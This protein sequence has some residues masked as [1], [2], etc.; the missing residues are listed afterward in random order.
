MRTTR[1][2]R[3]SS[4][5]L[6]FQTPGTG[7]CTSATTNSTLPRGQALARPKRKTGFSCPNSY[8]GSFGLCGTGAAY[9]EEFWNCAGTSA[10]LASSSLRRFCLVGCV[11]DRNVVSLFLLSLSRARVSSRMSKTKNDLLLLTLQPWR[12]STAEALVGQH[13]PASGRSLTSPSVPN[14]CFGSTVQQAIHV[15][16]KGNAAILY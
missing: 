2:P 7:A 5:L 13:S 14:N 10:G 8:I 15:V 12:A 1:P 3:C 6:S 9:P 4:T 16:Y 11:F